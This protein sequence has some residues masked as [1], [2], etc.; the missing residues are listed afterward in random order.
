M[1]FLKNLAV[2]LNATGP[3]AIISLVIIGVTALGLLRKGDLTA[4]ALG[5][6]SSL[7]VKLIFAFGNNSR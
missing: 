3:P 4:S 7:G 2:S 1:V 6:L 5:I